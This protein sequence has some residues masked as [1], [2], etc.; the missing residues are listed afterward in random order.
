MAAFGGRGSFGSRGAFGA[1]VPVEAGGTEYTGSI[2]EL[3]SLTDSYVSSVVFN[4]TLTENFTLADTYGSVAVFVGTIVESSS[5]VDTYASELISGSGIYA[6]TILETATLSDS[7]VSV[8]IA[9]G[10]ILESGTLS[11]TYTSI[12]NGY[13]TITETATINFTV[14][15][16]ILSSGGSSGGTGGIRTV[17]LNED[18]TFMVRMVSDSDHTTGV[19]GLT[20]SFNASKAGG[21]FAPLSPSVTD[22]GAGWY[23]VTISGSDL[24]TEGDYVFTVEGTGADNQA[25]V[26]QVMLGLQDAVIAALQQANLLTVGKFLA[27]K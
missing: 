27:L 15:G 22:R 18:Y 3:I 12:W 7:Y 6:G 10:T 14:S 23:A 13:V 20:L 26:S 11:D 5:L 24:D 9:K 17:P 4:S 8:L 2:S 25:V 1:G 16:S 21:A 19:S